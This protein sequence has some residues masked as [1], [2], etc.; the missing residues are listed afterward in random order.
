MKTLKN[1]LNRHMVNV[2]LRMQRRAEKAR[3]TLQ[4]ND[5]QFVVDHAIVFVIILVLG[6]IALLLM[7]NWLKDSLAPT[8]QGKVADFFN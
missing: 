5:G 6:A 3:D 8:L 7:K 2:C 4:E 1:A